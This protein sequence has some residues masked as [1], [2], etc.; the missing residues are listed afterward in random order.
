MKCIL[1]IQAGYD[2]E[3]DEN[4]SELIIDEWFGRNRIIRYSSP[5]RY[6]YFRFKKIGF[7]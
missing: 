3:S 5:K 6:N 1:N 7:K 4:I 2:Y